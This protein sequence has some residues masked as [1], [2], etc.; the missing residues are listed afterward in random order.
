MSQFL[1]V[2]VSPPPPPFPSL[3]GKRSVRTRCAREAAL[4]GWCIKISNRKK[5]KK[6]NLQQAQTSVAFW[7]QG[8]LAPRNPFLEKANA[9]CL[10]LLVDS[11][12]G[13]GNHRPEG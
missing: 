10:N 5:K 11:F 13:E 12:G 6:K 1:V 9:W 3:A 4:P 8:T 7:L 2:L